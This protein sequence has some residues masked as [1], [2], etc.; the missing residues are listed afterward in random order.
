MPRV[1]NIELFNGVVGKLFALLYSQFPHYAEIDF[2]ALAT[3]LI[4]KDDYDGGFEIGD[5]T[6]STVRWL[7]DADYIWLRPPESLGAE[8]KH[9]ATLSPK[10]FEALKQI[11]E[12]LDSKKTLGEKIVD[13]SK[14]K[15]NEG[16]TEAVGI[17]I[18]QGFKLMI[19]G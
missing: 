12:S 4:D 5:F 2:N 17:A 10:G 15:M 1:G 19:G 6:E 8:F 3:D 16:L 9:T 13:F 14:G 7:A 11:P 18:S